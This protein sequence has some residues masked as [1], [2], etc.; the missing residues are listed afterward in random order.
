MERSIWR[1]GQKIVRGMR[2]EGSVNF[3]IVRN[4]AERTEVCEVVR[5]VGNWVAEYGFEY[6]CP[7]YVSKI[8]VSVTERNMDDVLMWWH[9]HSAMYPHLSQMALDYLTVPG[10]SCSFQLQGNLTHVHCS[11]ICWCGTCIHGW[12]VLSHVRSRLSAQST[13]AL[14]C[15]G[16]WSLGGLVVDSDVLAVG[17]LAD[18]EGDEEQ[19]LGESWDDI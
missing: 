9:E 5:R 4:Y 17:S 15:L 7:D 18:V 10:E 8:G 11:Y 12:L 13:Q 19:E 14:V 16:S 2:S 6:F 1:Q 3:G